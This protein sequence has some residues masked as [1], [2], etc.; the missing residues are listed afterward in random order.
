MKPQKF[1]DEAKILFRMAVRL[2]KSLEADAILMLM[3]G[4]TD[5]KAL[6]RAAAK[7]RIV[8][9]ADHKEEVAG[10]V[11]AGFPV[12]LLDMADS[13]VHERLTQALLEAVADDLLTPG[14][15]VIAL[16]SGFDPGTVDSFS[17]IRLDEHLGK[18]TA[19]DLR[20]LETRVPLDTLKTVVDLAVEIGREGREGKPVGTLLVV[21]D[22][23]KVMAHSHPTG[24][25]PVK[26]TKYNATKV[27]ALLNDE[28]IIRNR[29]K[30]AASI[31]N[32]QSFLKVQKEFDSF[33]KYM[34]DF[35]GGKPVKNKRKTMK[36]VPAKTEISDIFSKDL[37]KRGFKFVGST[38]IY[39]HMQAVGM[40][41]D[42]LVHCFR[43]KE[44]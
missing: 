13:P 31:T 36:D 25:D 10:A 27:K 37:K 22:A 32:A 3:D 39:A 19:R 12:V 9:G 15:E 43:Y 8:I 7:Q 33:A 30:I 38:I 26:V 34:W 35:V 17:V 16:Y 18:L 5:W 44:V 29:L 6:R 1:T 21:G 14:A 20:Q 40:V 4:P 28:G 23:R 41:N 11:E 2:A 42:H 24:F